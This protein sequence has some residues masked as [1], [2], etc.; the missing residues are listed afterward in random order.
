[1]VP[2]MGPEI[3]CLQGPLCPFPDMIQGPGNAKVKLK[4]EIDKNSSVIKAVYD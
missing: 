2:A 4:L 1:M 3:S